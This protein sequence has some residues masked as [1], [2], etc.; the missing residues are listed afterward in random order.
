[1]VAGINDLIC[2][3]TSPEQYITFFAA[4]F[5]PATGTLSYV[6]AGHNAPMLLH[7]DARV[8]LLGE[9]GPVLGCL[10]GISY[11][12]QAVSAN[13]GDLLLLYTDGASEAMN[14]HGEEFGEKRILQ[15]LETGKT[16]TPRE[17]LE[18]LEWQTATHRG[19]VAL[20]DDFTLLVA[21]V[22]SPA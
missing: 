5:D 3:S 20:Y 22:T 7:Q 10:T 12:Q 16:R 1:V 6:N 13:K 9:G 18:L 19:T 11:E 15:C 17:L 4:V 21:R 2:Q 8:E 14:E